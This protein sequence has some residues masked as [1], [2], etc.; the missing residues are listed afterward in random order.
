[1]NIMNEPLIKKEDSLYLCIDL[2]AKLMP[3][4]ND[5]D[6]VIKNTNLLFRTADIHNIPTLITEQYPK[7]LGAT[8]ERIILPKNHKL[9]AKEYFTVFGSEDFVKEFNFI[10]KKNIIVFGVEAHVCVYYSV[11]HLIENGYNVYVV[12]DAVSSRTKEN[13]EIALNQMRKLGANIVSTE[14]ILFG[15]IEHCKV[16]C[17]KEVSKLLKE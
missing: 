6:T 13:K 8:D 16:D 14:M 4:I 17:F 11:V 5:I 7:G 15:H 1:M 3:A 12:A 9:F 2:Q 10:N